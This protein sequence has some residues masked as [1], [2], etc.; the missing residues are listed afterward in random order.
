[1]SE[2]VLVLVAVV[3][4]CG[5]LYWLAL[6]SRRK[7]PVPLGDLQPELDKLTHDPRASASLVERERARSPELSERELL[8]VVVRR[9]RRERRR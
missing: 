7:R 1:M 5:V 9:L 6:R 3:A 8:S 2:R 4:A